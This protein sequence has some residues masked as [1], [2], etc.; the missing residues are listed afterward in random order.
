MTGSGTVAWMLAAL[1][2]AGCGSMHGGSSDSDVATNPS[3]AAVASGTVDRSGTSTSNTQNTPVSAGYQ[4]APAPATPVATTATTGK[5]SMPPA[6]AAAPSVVKKSIGAWVSCTGTADDTAGVAQAFA[7]AKNAAFTLVVDCPVRMHLGIDIAKGIFIDNGTSVEFTSAG[8]FFVDNIFHP[9]FVIAD[10]NNI[11]LTNWNVEWDGSMPVNANLGGYELDGKFVAG[12]GLGQP[13]AAFNDSILTQWLATNRGVVFNETQGWVKSIWVGGVNL[14]AVF[15]ITGSTS[16]LVVTGMNLGVPKSAGGNEFIPMAFS[17]SPNW[18]SNQTVTGKTVHAVPYAAVPHGLTFSNIDFDGTLM[19]WQGNVQDAMF[20]NIRSQ[21]Y[22]D[23]QDANGGNVGGIGKWFP[24]PHL[25]YLN[26]ITTGDPSLFNSN[27]HISNVVDSGPRIGTARDKGGTDTISGYALSLKLGCNDCS[28]D[29]YTSSRPDG[30]MDVLP[31]DGLTVS[32]VTATWDSTFLNNMFPGLRFPLE[33]YSHVTFENVQMKDLASVSTKGPIGNAPYQTNSN[34]V[35]NNVQIGMNK[36][37]GSDIPVPNI[38][39]ANNNVVINFSMTA[40]PSRVTSL[41]KGSAVLTL[42]AIPST[43]SVGAAT[44]LKWIVKEGSDC[45]ASGA[46]S[47]ALA[48][49]GS[50]A[51]RITSAG[52]HDFT[53]TC[54]GS[55]GAATTTV[56]VQAQ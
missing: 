1:L 35:F 7:A 38:V 54:H 29:Q 12:A 26:Y 23:L 37:G 18:T 10:S 4:P 47:G 41:Q 22:G 14:S 5:V 48:T 8:K 3:G 28:V 52:E 49:G 11:T 32:N 15:Y 17:L 13:A 9:A 19:G 27:I 39:G 46:W 25:F 42:Q 36:W 30:F 33:G 45:S 53:L 24:P 16:N 43:V 51:V 40:D 44:L 20:E 2:V 21:R 50:K 55:N 6:V 56:A 31:S 34:I